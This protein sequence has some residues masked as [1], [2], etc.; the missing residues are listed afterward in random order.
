[1]GTI[2]DRS[3]LEPLRRE[4]FH[5]TRMN[6]LD[7]RVIEKTSRYAGLIGDENEFETCVAQ[8]VHA[9]NGAWREFGEIGI[10]EIYL[11][12]DDCAITIKQRIF[13]RLGSWHYFK[14]SIFAFLII[15]VVLCPA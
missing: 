1:M 5:Q 10:A 4:Q 12:D 2:V 7:R 11:V 9:F 8:A 3:Q 15:E 13:L 14:T 6:A